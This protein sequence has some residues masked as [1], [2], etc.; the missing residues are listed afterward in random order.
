MSNFLAP[1]QRP[2]CLNQILSATQELAAKEKDTFVKFLTAVEEAQREYFRINS[3]CSLKFTHK[4][5]A[6]GTKGSAD[7]SAFRFAFF[8]Y[9][10]YKY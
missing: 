4:I 1:I 9:T 3:V 6:P 7:N 2:A 8:F 5:I 10:R